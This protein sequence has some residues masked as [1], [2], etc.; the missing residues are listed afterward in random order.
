[1]P[2]VV[3]RFGGKDGLLDA[4]Q[5]RLAKEITERRRIS[6]GDIGLAIGILMEDYEA[7]GDLVM[8]VL[9]QEERHPPF[10]AMADI[11]RVFHRNWIASVFAPWLEG[12]PDAARQARLD[13]FVIATDIYVWK[14]ARRDMGRSRA[15]ALSLFHT[16][17]EA[18]IGTATEASALPPQEPRNV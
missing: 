17:V 16:L 12:L 5:K 7:T 6:P 8:R 15:E 2:T 4:V 14:L 1:M 18:V 10:K 13:A 3:R 9:A 11:G